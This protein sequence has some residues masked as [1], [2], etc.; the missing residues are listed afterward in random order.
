MSQEFKNK[1]DYSIEVYLGSKRVLALTF[2]HS[3]YKITLWLDK[4]NIEWSVINIYAR[5]SRRFITRQYKKDYIVDKP[6]L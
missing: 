6:K 3:I 1:N 4:K 2:V 5:R